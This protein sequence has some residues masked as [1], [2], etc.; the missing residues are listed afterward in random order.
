MFTYSNKKSKSLRVIITT[1]IA[2]FKF[3]TLSRSNL[4][5][6]VLV[7]VQALFRK[8]ALAEIH[9][10]LQVLEHDGLVDLLPCS[11]LLTF[12]DIV[13]NIQGWLLL[14]NLQ[15]LCRKAP[16]LVYHPYAVARPRR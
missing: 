2:T 8:V 16:Y 11:M 4:L 14:A 3:D 15:E 5:A 13:K 6:D 9:A 10:E 12:D 7:L 1:Q